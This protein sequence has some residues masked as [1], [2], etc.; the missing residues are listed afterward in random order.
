MWVPR[1]MDGRGG[2]REASRPWM[3][4]QGGEW[5]LCCPQREL[6]RGSMTPQAT[7]ESLLRGH[8]VMKVRQLTSTSFEAGL[9]LEHRSPD[10]Q[11]E[12]TPHPASSLSRPPSGCGVCSEPGQ[13]AQKYLFMSRPT[14]PSGGPQ[15]GYLT[16]KFSYIT[17]S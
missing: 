3:P 16:E 10:S 13:R 6:T 2:R 12:L 9:G 11:P 4:G 15:G 7:L 1:C 5:T 14:L 17:P 8:S